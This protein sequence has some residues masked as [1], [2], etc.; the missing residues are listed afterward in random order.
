MVTLMPYR[1]NTRQVNIA[2]QIK[3]LYLTTVQVVSTEKG[4]NHKTV[5]NMIK[6]FTI[7]VKSLLF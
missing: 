5:C 6:L 7:F 1:D 4:R 2:S 3:T